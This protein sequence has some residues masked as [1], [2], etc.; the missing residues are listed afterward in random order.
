MKQNTDIIIMD[1]SGAGGRIYLAKNPG[2]EAEA[3]VSPHRGVIDISLHGIGMLEYWN[4]GILGRKSECCLIWN[5]HN[6]H[7]SYE[8]GRCP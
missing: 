5:D 2:P 4:T 1:L 8:A 6:A 7:I 3:L